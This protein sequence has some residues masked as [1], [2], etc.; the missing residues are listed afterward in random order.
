VR[1][2]CRYWLV[3]DAV[4]PLDPKPDEQELIP[5][6]MLSVPVPLASHLSPLYLCAFASLADVAKGEDGAKSALR[7]ILAL[8][9]AGSLA[10][11]KAEE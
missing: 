11:T 5:T 6:L 10:R 9:G 3:R 4:N 8:R 1:S 7:E 2:A